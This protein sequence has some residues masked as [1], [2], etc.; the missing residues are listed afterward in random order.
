MEE[1]LAKEI[2]KI[3]RDTARQNESAM[4]IRHL[5]SQT[6]ERK[7]VD[8]GAEARTRQKG[9]PTTGQQTRRPE[10]NRADAQFS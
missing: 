10:E 3:P 8:E 5:G 6:N 9:K 4:G 1:Q 7:R 2:R